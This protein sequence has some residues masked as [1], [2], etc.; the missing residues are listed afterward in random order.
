MSTG[1]WE[2]I[3]IGTVIDDQH[4]YYETNNLNVTDFSSETHSKIWQV[5]SDLAEKA[6]LSERSLIEGLKDAG[7][8]E[9]LGDQSIRGEEYVRYLTSMSDGISFPEA[10]KMVIEASDKRYIGKIAQSLYQNTKNGLTPD[11]IIDD[12][13]VE[14]LKVR[15]TRT[16]EPELIGMSTEDIKNETELKRAGEIKPRWKFPILAFDKL[17][18]GLLD[19]DF[20]VMVA[21]TGSGKSSFVRNVAWATAKQ[22]YNIL[23]FNYENTPHE[24]KTWAIAQETGID[25]KK[26]IW[27]RLASNKE[28]EVIQEAWK[29]LEGVPWKIIEM[30]GDPITT[31]RRM[32]R[33]EMM[34]GNLDLIQIDGAYLIGGKRDSAYDLISSNMQALRSLAQELKVPIMATT[35]FNRGVKSK[36]TPETDD[37]LYAGENPAR[38][39]TSII[40]K[41]ITP[42]QAKLFPENFDENG[43][44]ILGKR[45]RAVVVN[46]FVIKQTNGETGQT[47]DIKWIKPTQRFE[48]LEDNW[49][50]FTTP[51]EA[52]SPDQQRRNDEQQEIVDKLK[53]QRQKRFG[54]SGGAKEKGQK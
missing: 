3:V 19:P 51:P 1:N 12:H 54:Q 2:Q 36:T 6:A 10:V 35:Q 38:I 29:M 33:I 50:P 40:Q 24:C 46:G 13:M 14:L 16:R 20:L 48:T 31:I 52:V 15:R 21:P 53:E 5:A 4:S 43:K 37:I 47:L 18:P 23:T 30:G 17:I 9:N 8:L 44:L 39:I 34:K 42:G 27:P 25:H 32:A 28:F 49:V 7:E 26:I 22:G 11:E 41:E 45:M